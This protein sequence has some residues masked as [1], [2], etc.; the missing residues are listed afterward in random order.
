MMSCRGLCAEAV[1][2]PLG[3]L[4]V[5]VAD[6]LSMLADNLLMQLCCQ[7]LPEWIKQFLCGLANSSCSY[8]S[9]CTKDLTLFSS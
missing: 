7:D 3:Q 9:F 5:L 8:R 2:K 1:W 6:L 4:D